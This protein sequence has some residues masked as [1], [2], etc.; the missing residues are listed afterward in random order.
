[1]SEPA[2]DLAIVLAILSSCKEKVIGDDVFCF[3]EVGLLGEVRD[4]SNA[5]QRLKE[6]SKLGFKKAIIPKSATDVMEDDCGLEIVAV[7]NIRQA[8]DAI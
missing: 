1:M 5:Q 2:V 3:G 4:V 7:S 6:A 8:Y